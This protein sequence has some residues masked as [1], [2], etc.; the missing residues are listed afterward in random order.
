MPAEP[1]GRRRAATR[2]PPP[3]PSAERDPPTRPP[4]EPEELSYHL[5]GVT[6]LDS[7]PS[8]PLLPADRPA[9]RPPLTGGLAGAVVREDRGVHSE[10]EGFAKVAEE[11]ERAR[12]EYPR[13]VVDRV[14]TAASVGE[15]DVIVDLAAGTGKLTRLLVGRGAR[16]VAV[17]PVAEMRNRLVAGLP[18]GEAVEAV[19][20]TAEA[21]GLPAGMARL[22]TVGQAFHWFANELALAEMARVIE[23]EG[24]LAL[25]WNRRDL[26]QPIQ[27]AITAVIAPYRQDTPSHETRE[28]TVVMEQTRLFSAPAE[29]TEGF[30]QLLTV[31]G[32]ADRVGSISFIAN[33]S[34]GERARVLSRVRDLM[35]SGDALVALRYECEAYLYRR[36][37]AT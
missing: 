5:A 32:L 14:V 34:D 29:E 23:P 24:Y 11:Y 18:D 31:E 6:L 20:G 13:A 3:A 10:A 2:R 12:P 19:A 30:E 27:A 21:T 37:T 16:V 26:A 25:V 22:L 17:E 33:L 15:G 9:H 1:V 35:P 8:A 36:Q 28:W 7:P 4:A